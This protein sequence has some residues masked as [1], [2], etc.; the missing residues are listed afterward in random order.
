MTKVVQIGH[1]GV[2]GKRSAGSGLTVVGVIA[3]VIIAGS[4]SSNNPGAGRNAVGPASTTTSTAGTS[5]TL[6][7]NDPSP[8]PKTICS[9]A[10]SSMAVFFVP[11]ASQSQ[12][13]AVR[14]LL[15]SDPR[16]G[17][18]GFVDQAQAYREYQGLFA[19]TPGAHTLTQPELPP[20]LRV[21]FATSL[22]PTALRSTVENMAG[23]VKVGNFP[24]SNTGHAVAL[25]TTV[26]ERPDWQTTCRQA[27][28][29]G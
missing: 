7:P 22:P 10:R 12:I 9:F 6:P 19:G 15:D 14:Q 5:Y 13:D 27:A 20:S 26:Y 18:V 1:Y 11:E 17:I 3:A 16:V 28:I 8:L 2:V 21:L 24:G 23:V 29:V 4:C 25:G